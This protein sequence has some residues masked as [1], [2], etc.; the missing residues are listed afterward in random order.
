MRA[1]SSHPISTIPDYNV[2]MVLYQRVL[3]QQCSDSNKI[4]SRHEPDVK[5]YTK[6]K[7]HMKFEFG[8]KASFLV[9]QET[10][11]IMGALN[12]TEPIHDSK[13][14]PDVLEKCERLPGKE[15]LEI[16]VNTGQK[17][18]SE[19]KS[20]KIYVPNPEKNISKSKRRKNSRRAAIEPLISFAWENYV[21]NNDTLN[22]AVE[23]MTNSSI[24]VVVGYSFPDFNREFDSL[25]LSEGATR[26]IQ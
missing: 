5:C 2:Q 6:G 23:I 13:T 16:C 4:Y 7:E 3:S 9:C 11:I 22:K 26:L 15:A 18:K 19:S 1:V 25:L 14:L 8:S 20:S 24:L 12:V 17:D 10:G 21:S